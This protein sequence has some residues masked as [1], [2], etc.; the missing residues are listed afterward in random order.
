MFNDAL[1]DNAPLFKTISEYLDEAMLAALAKAYQ[2]GRLLIIG[3]TDLDAQQPVFWNIGAIA[4]S[5]HP[6][7]LNNHPPCPARFRRDTRCFPT[8]HVRRDREWKAVSRDAC[9]W[10]RLRPGVPLPGH[11]VTRLRRLRMA[12]GVSVIPAVAYIIRNG[13]L[14]PEWASTERST[15]SIAERAINTM[16]SASG[17]NDVIA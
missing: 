9:G 14:D 15:L 8:D 7:A 3:T 13:R 4:S 1:T 2:D 17:M 6:R 5:G 16:I 10:R 12:T 11:T